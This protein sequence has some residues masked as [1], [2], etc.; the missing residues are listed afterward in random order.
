MRFNLPHSNAKPKATAE[1]L[2][3][4]N[5]MTGTNWT[6][7]FA[8]VCKDF[9][10]RCIYTFTNHRII[11]TFSAFEMTVSAARDIQLKDELPLVSLKA[12]TRCVEAK[13]EVKAN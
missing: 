7:H 10:I 6:E 2:G 4:H 11:Y 5:C 9:H 13:S 3:Y 12:F 8:P 1:R